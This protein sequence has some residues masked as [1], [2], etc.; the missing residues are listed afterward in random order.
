MLLIN[1]FEIIY[2][3][4]QDK[5]C[6]L[7]VSSIVSSN[8]NRINYIIIPDIN[9]VHTNNT[10]LIFKYIILLKIYYNTGYFVNI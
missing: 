1:L 8:S 10:P 3:E 6:Q 7:D 4:L 9:N 2:L 5:I